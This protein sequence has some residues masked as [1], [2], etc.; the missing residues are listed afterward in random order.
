MTKHPSKNFVPGKLQH[1]AI[2][3]VRA[4]KVLLHV[5][6]MLEPERDHGFNAT[7][8]PEMAGTRT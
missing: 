7:F 8:V 1:S 3:G 4:S 6:L 2:Q 5:Y